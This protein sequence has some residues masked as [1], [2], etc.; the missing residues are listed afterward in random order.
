VG[1][2]LV[3]ILGKFHPESA[4]RFATIHQEA[5]P[6]CARKVF[7]PIIRAMIPEV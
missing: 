6:R 7:N 1:T 2:N 4:E 3:K 5:S